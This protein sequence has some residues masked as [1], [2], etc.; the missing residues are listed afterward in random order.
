MKY[1]IKKG[2]QNE[3][4]LHVDGTQSICPFVQPIPMQGNMGQVQLHRLPCTSVCPLAS[5]NG[6]DMWTTYCGGKERSFKVEEELTSDV[7][8]IVK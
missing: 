4:N 1:T 7:L 8:H 6:I 3:F 2:V 5:Y